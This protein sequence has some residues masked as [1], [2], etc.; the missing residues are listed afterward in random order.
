MPIHIL[1][2]SSLQHPLFSFHGLYLLHARMLFV[3]VFQ[4]CTVQCVGMSSPIQ[5]QCS[6]LQADSVCYEL[7]LLSQNCEMA[8]LSLLLMLG[9]KTF[10]PHI[11]LYKLS[12]CV[13]PYMFTSDG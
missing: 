2:V 5:F 3:H 13:Y 4:I 9:E 11:R 1:Q 10:V 12:V 8:T 7:C 6:C